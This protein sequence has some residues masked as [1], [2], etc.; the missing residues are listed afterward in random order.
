MTLLAQG[1]PY[2][3][4]QATGWLFDSNN[5][6]L[7]PAL[8]GPQDLVRGVGRQAG[9][10]LTIGRSL[11]NQML[12]P[13][14]AMVQTVPGAETNTFTTRVA[15]QGTLV[16]PM[17]IGD[18]AQ[19]AGT[20]PAGALNLLGRTLR[21]SG[22]GTMG[23]TSTPN[24][25]IDL[26]L[27]AGVLATTLAKAVVAITSPGSFHFV[28]LSTVTT[29]GASGVMNTTGKLNYA[30][31]TNVTNTWALANSTP[32]TGLSVDLTTALALSVNATCSASSASN[33]IILTNL[34]VEIL[35]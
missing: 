26:G 30:S 27:G 5:L 34:V 6:D 9:S 7:V 15:I 3:A 10:G 32:G 24:F 33:R 35:F 25:T 17:T 29:A 8:T 28:M 21:I 16:N 14:L 13:G 4:Q 31:A 18:A 2:L 20:F 1:T 19:T 23:S 11:V 22:G 12:P